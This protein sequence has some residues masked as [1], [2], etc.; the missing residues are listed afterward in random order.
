VFK[1]RTDPEHF[2]LVGAKGFTLPFCKIDLRPGGVMHCC[3]RS[4]EGQDIWCTGVYR[5]VVEPSLLVS[6]DFFS[7]EEGSLVQPSHYGMSPEPSETLVTVTFAE[8]DGKTKLTLQQGVLKSVTERHGAQQG[9]TE[10]L[11]RLAD[12]LAQA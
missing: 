6:T 12:Y 2:A 10:T 7:D 4:P 9:W 11:D 5:E 3:M 8:H 1:A